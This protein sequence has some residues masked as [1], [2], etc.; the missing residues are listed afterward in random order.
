MLL[1][2]APQHWP[3]VPG[4]LDDFL[5]IYLRDRAT[6]GLTEWIAYANFLERR[7][8]NQFQELAREEHELLLERLKHSRRK[9]GTESRSKRWPRGLLFPPARSKPGRKKGQGSRLAEAREVLALQAT[10]AAAG[11]NLRDTEALAKWFALKGKATYRV[12]ENRAIL[13][14]MSSLRKDH[15][16]ACRVT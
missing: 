8:A 6:W 10:Y 15:K 14:A 12:R 16:I 2:S 1:L 9:A 5:R 11:K 3:P 4:L 13:N 7:G